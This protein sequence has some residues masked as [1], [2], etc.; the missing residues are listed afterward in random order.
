M[1]TSNREMLSLARKWGYC[2]N[3]QLR[4]LRARL[5]SAITS[6]EPTRELWDQYQEISD[7][8]VDFPGDGPRAT[9]ARCGRQIVQAFINFQGGNT[10][11][12]LTYLITAET[13]A[14]ADDHWSMEGGELTLEIAKHGSDAEQT[15]AQAYFYED[16][17]QLEDAAGAFEAALLIYHEAHSD[18]SLTGAHRGLVHQH[19]SECYAGYLRIGASDSVWL[20]NQVVTY[21]ESAARLLEGT[22]GFARLKEFRSQL[23]ATDWWIGALQRQPAYVPD[24]RP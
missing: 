7:P 12:G 11:L 18:D 10:V 15:Q 19:I 20:Q 2:E 3:E 5:V 4:F 21:V 14:L 17:G 24:Y 8:L 22:E 6:G 16:V 23:E 1:T 13:V 9:R